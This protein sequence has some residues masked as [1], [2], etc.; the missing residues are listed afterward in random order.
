MTR[1]LA[2]SLSL[3]AATFVVGIAIGEDLKSGL[4]VGESAQAFQV[5]NVTGQACEVDYAKDGRG[6]LCYR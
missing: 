1:G 3:L 6:S 5:R 2:V 4:Q